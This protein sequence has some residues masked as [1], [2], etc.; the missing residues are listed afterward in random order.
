MDTESLRRLQVIQLDKERGELHEK[1][2]TTGKRIDHFERAL[3]REE[4]PLLNQDYEI[5]LAEES[6]LYEKNRQTKLT[7]AAARH[8]ENVNL[9]KHLEKI[10]PDYTAYRANIAEKKSEE[11]EARQNEAHQ[12][13]EAEKAKRRAAY[14]KYKEEEK[15]KRIERERQEETERER[16]LKEEEERVA[17]EE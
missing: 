4:I 3:R 5:Q 12:T 17:K 1:L 10:L 7:L 15:R 13:L 6:R 11:F 9:K 8:K 16:L 2:R 14:N